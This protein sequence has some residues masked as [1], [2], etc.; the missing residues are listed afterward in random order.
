MFCWLGNVTGLLATGQ[1]Y[2]NVRTSAHPHGE[3]RGQFLALA[4]T[5]S[6]QGYAILEFTIPAPRSRLPPKARRHPH[7]VHR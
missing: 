6:G 7:Q 3:T 5:R 4:A 2:F 1:T